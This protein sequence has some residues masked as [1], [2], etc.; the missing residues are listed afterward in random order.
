MGFGDYLTQKQPIFAKTFSNALSCKQIAHAY[1]VIGESGTPLKQTAIFMAKSI[2][3]DGDGP[4]ADES[5]ITC[6]RIE[7]GE[8][9]DFRFFDGSEESIKKEQMKNVVLDF[10]QTPLE[11][12]GIMVYVVHLVENMTAEAANSLLKFL[13]EP[14]PNTYAILTAQNESKV[15]PT[16]VSRCQTLHLLLAP[17]SEVVEECLKLQIERSDAELLS[18]FDNDASL[19][20]E[21]SQEEDYLNAKKALE[22]FLAAMNE[23]SSQARYVMEKEVTPLLSGKPAARFFFDLLSVVFQDIVAYARGS[24]INLTAYAKIIADLAKKLPHVE[25]SLLSVMTLR[26]EIETNIQVGLL[27]NHLIYLLYQEEP[28]GRKQ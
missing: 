26:G 19:I 24:S 23:N 8:Y 12:K 7:A 13:E 3:C 6:Q 18:F 17:R 9:P 20:L 14:S 10:Q 21:K 11:T 5:C 27:C 4:F 25:T 15:L 1:L 2:L 22:R 16:I 28:H